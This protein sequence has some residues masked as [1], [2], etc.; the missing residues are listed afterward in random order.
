VEAVAAEW[1]DQGTDPEARDL[2]SGWAAAV[3]VRAAVEQ[4]AAPARQE[5]AA[6]PTYGI[7]VPPAAVVAV[8]AAE[9]PEQAEPGLAVG[10]EGQAAVAALVQVP[11]AQAEVA[12][13]AG[14]ELLERERARARAVQAAGL[15]LVAEAGPVVLAAVGTEVVEEQERALAVELE[16]AAVAARGRALVV[17]QAAGATGVVEEQERVGE[18]E[19]LEPAG[20]SEV[21]EEKARRR[22]N[23]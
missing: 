6:V 18:A 15:V 12:E 3:A 14:V 23:G 20:E 22:E 7:R 10:Q 16:L 5:V 11:V 19:G 17:A 13:A 8:L 21:Q 9:G 4:V 2:V 1:V